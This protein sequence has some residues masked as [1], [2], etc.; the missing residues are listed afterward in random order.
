MRC[1]YDGVHPCGK[2]PACL[3]NRQRA[4][5]FRLDQEKDVCAFYYWLTLQYDEDHVPHLE[6]GEM[7]FSKEHCRS[8]FEKLR[9]RYEPNGYKF[10]HF[11]VSE[12]GPTSTHRPHYHCLLMVYSD[13]PL[14]ELY[15]ARK[16]MKEFIIEKAWEN[17]HVTEKS[18]HGRVLTYLTKYCCKPELLGQKHTM[19][20]FTLISRGI[21]LSYLDKLSDERK[22]QMIEKLDFTVHYGKSKIQLP[23]YY[24]DKIM[25]HSAQLE[26]DYL[27]SGDWDSYEQLHA[28]RRR[29]FD[30][31]KMITFQRVGGIIEQ[32]YRDEIYDRE[33]RISANWSN[34]KSKV[35]SRKDL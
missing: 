15:L 7:C 19:Q 14:H 35:N 17:G 28:L 26:R 3:L 33:N 16:E 34:F 20:P 4:F 11:L 9:K 13:K 18:F 6:N 1:L 8:F 12:Y 10:K 2:C 21:G 23:R 25:P 29:I 5:C 22:R 30:K 27:S 31:Q 32:D 24:V